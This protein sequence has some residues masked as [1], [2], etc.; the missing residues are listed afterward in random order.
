MPAASPRALCR[1]TDPFDPHDDVADA[2]GAAAG[3]KRPFVSDASSG[4]WIAEEMDLVRLSRANA[5]DRGRGD[6]V[7]LRVHHR[8][9]ERQIEPIGQAI[10]QRAG[11]LT[12]RRVDGVARGDDVGAA[13]AE[14]KVVVREDGRDA[15]EIEPFEP[16]ERE[17]LE[18]VVERE[19][20]RVRSSRR[21]R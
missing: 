10:G 5:F 13:A 17:V 18:V 11:P 12:D 14:L 21:D 4:V 19:A 7:Q 1:N 6:D 8:D 15:R 9:R 20:A 16:I 2:A 3:L